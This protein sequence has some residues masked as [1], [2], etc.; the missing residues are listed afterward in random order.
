M[1]RERPGC[2]SALVD[3]EIKAAIGTGVE[4]MD[5]EG[6][7]VV[8]DLDGTLVDTAPDLIAAV[9]YVLGG[10]GYRPLSDAELRPTISFGGRHMISVGLQLQGGLHSESEVDALFDTFVAFYSRN[11]AVHSR[12]F[13]GLIEELDRLEAAGATLAVCTNKREGLARQ[14]LEELGMLGRFKALTGADTFPVRKPHPDHF[15]GTVERAGGDRAT[16]LMIG[17]SDTDVQTAKAAGV[18]VIGVTFGY[19]DVPV[20]ELSCDAVISHYSELPNALRMALSRP[21]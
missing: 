7:T 14:L 19:T 9:N 4:W 21:A 16:S 18:P 11:I 6:R 13:P 10:R 20:T 15:H 8:F 12:P 3:M 17:D 2:M 5:L 1:Y